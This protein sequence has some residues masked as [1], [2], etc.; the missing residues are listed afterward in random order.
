MQRELA[1]RDVLFFATFLDQPLGQLRAFAIGNHPAGNVAAEHVEDYVE[2]KVGP[3][4]GAEQLANVPAPELIGSSSH[5]FGLL[6]RRMKQLIAAF[7]RF[8]VFL[9]HA[10]HGA[11]RAVI[12]SFIEQRR[13]NSGWRAIL[14]TFFVQ[15]GEN[16][17]PFLR[18]QSPCRRPPG[19]RRSRRTG[20]KLAVVGS[21]RQ[22]QRLA[23]R[24]DARDRGQLGGRGHH[25]FSSGSGIGRPSS[26][27]FFFCTSMMISAFRSFSVSWPSWRRSFSFSSASGSRWD[28]RPRLRGVRASRLP[29]WRSRRQ[30][31]RCEEYKPSRRSS[32]PTPPG[33]AAA[34]SAS[35]TMRSLYAAVKTRRFALATTSGSGGKTG[36]APAPTL[37]AAALRSGSQTEPSL[38]SAAAK[39][40]GERTTPREF[41]IIPACFFLALLLIN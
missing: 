4:D 16:R 23:R 8:V 5:Q 13:V 3:L 35:C 40:S 15:A 22:S 19:N 20:M 18:A 33:V 32:A 24:S 7:V 26:A 30:L 2:I 25:S 11:D 1:G 9:E 27:A 36:T 31:T 38:R 10:I 37:A 34:S 41:L 21:S 6:V 14:I 29:A 12:R 28:L 17:L 39:P